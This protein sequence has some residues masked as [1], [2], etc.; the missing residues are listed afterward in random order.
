MSATIDGTLLQAV[1]RASS[2]EQKN[3]ALLIKNDP[4]D[5]ASTEPYWESSRRLLGAATGHEARRAPIF[6]AL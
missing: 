5:R 3:N 4:S 2:L 1:R 6:F